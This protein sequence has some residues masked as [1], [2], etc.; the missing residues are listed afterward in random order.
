MYGLFIRFSSW[1]YYVL[2]L[3]LNISLLSSG[4]NNPIWNADISKK[5]PKKRE[6][7]NWTTVSTLPFRPMHLS[8]PSEL[9]DY[10]GFWN[11]LYVRLLEYHNM[12]KLRQLQVLKQFTSYNP[13]AHFSWEAAG[14]LIHGTQLHNKQ[15]SMCVSSFTYSWLW[16]R[17]SVIAYISFFF[18]YF[19]SIPK[20]HLYFGRWKAKRDDYPS[21]S[22]LQISDSDTNLRK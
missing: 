18:S 3:K 21:A 13:S 12:T 17:S 9:A 1:I 6:N 10:I 5:K 7:C 20:K 22:L 4:V 2:H 15:K 8:H 16:T 14:S 19:F 11:F